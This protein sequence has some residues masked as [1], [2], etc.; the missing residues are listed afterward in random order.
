MHRRDQ[1]CSKRESRTGT[2]DVEGRMSTKMRGND[3]IPM[4]LTHQNASPQVARH[5]ELTCTYMIF[6]I[7]PPHPPLLSTKVL[8]TSG[9]PSS[10]G[11]SS[12]P[13]RRWIA[14][15]AKKAVASPTLTAL[16]TKSIAL[17]KFFQFK[18]FHFSTTLDLEG[19]AFCR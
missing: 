17:V 3:G 8:T 1:T 7:K 12:Q 13:K 10:Q 9:P 14:E 4:M 11:Q 15:R 19:D 5:L 2:T 6:K 18:F 16:T